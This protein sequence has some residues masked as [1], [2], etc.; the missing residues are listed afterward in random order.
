MCRYYPATLPD[1]RKISGVGEAKLERYGD[2]FVRE[3]QNYLI[4]N[5]GIS[6][7]NRDSVN[8]NNSSLHKKIIPPHPP[9]A[10]GEI[11]R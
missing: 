4:D 8:T 10:K 9:L 7:K 2:I 5:P 3:I 6:I 1:M 11:C